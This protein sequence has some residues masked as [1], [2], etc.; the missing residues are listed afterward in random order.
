MGV[1]VIAEIGINHNGSMELATRLIEAAK[2]AGADAV[3]FQKRTIE[4]VYT[5]DELAQPRE[6]PFGT[7]NG[8]LKRG[9]EFDAHQYDQLHQ[10]CMDEE[11]EW[12]ASCWDVESVEFIARYNPPWLKIPSALITNTKL[13]DAYANTGIPLYLSTGMS[14]AKEVHRAAM[15]LLGHGCDVIPMACTSTYPC[16]PEELNLRYI[17]TLREEY[18][19]AGFSSHGVSPWP[20]L[21]AVALGACVVEAHLT[22]DRTLF[23]S[24][25]AASLEPKAFRKMVEE[26]RTMEV[27][28]GTGE[29][30]VYASE[31]PIKRKLR[32]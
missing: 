12:S 17:T 22:L 2:E 31:E 26:I 29:K 25:Q 10:Q 6:S 24:D 1:Y 19:K 5:E 8:E 18:W 9:L 23:G 13:L 11:I 21:G 20:M 14:T 3:K 16:P 7:T 15:R 28:L 4:A 27:A 30:V 32:R